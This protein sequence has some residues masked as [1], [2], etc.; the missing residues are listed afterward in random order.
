MKRLPALFMMLVIGLVSWG[1]Y[2]AELELKGLRIGMTE[3]QFMQLY[4]NAKCG[5]SP[6]KSD[7]PASIPVTRGCAIREFTLA[8]NETHEAMFVF[9]ENGLGSWAFS[10]SKD[11]YIK[12]QE[13]LTDKFGPASYKSPL[14]WK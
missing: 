8:T 10:F 5:P 11:D 1:V 6:R 3:E 7:W 2:A 4:P 13:A 9:F 14:I 12:L